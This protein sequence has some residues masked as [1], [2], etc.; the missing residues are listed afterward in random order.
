MAQQTYVQ[1]YY[2][3]TG[4]SATIYKENKLGK[5]VWVYFACLNIVLMMVFVFIFLVYWWII[6]NKLMLISLNNQ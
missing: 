4:M 6:N 2:K 1:K 5:H 3:K